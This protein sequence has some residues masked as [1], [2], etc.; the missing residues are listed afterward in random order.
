MLE[1]N[2]KI[3]IQSL[4]QNNKYFKTKDFWEALLI[5]SIS[6]EVIRS[7]KNDEENKDNQEKLNEKNANIVFSQLLSL[8]D[9]MFD[10]GVDGEM[11]KQIIEPRI[12][13]YK[14]DEKSRKPIN[15]YIESKIK[16]KKKNEK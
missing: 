16:A 1:N 8:I 5:Y 4:I 15:D 9:N 7:K 12:E 13:Y 10:F 2:N 3:Y 14:V 6:K 11:I